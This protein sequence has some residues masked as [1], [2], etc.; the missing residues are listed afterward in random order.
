MKNSYLFKAFFVLS[1]FVGFAYPLQASEK[2]AYMGG[3]VDLMEAPNG[4]MVRQ[5]VLET[6][7]RVWIGGEALDALAGQLLASLDAWHRREALRPGMPRGA[8]AGALPENAA[9]GSFE[10]ALARRFRQSSHC[11][12]RISTNFFLYQPD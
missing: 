11:R 2:S 7:A 6:A 4:A 9:P 1:I 12:R 8:L 10:L 5:E 3:E